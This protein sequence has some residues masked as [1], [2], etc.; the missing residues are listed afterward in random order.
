[1]KRSWLSLLGGMLVCLPEGQAQGGP[2]DAPPGYGGE[3]TLKAASEARDAKNQQTHREDSSKLVLPGLVADRVAKRIEVLA[4]TTELEK[5]AIIEFLLID[6]SCGRGYESLLWSFAKPSDV[7]HALEFIGLKSGEPY[8]PEAMRFWPKGERVNMTLQHSKD[9]KPARME[10]LILDKRTGKTLEETGFMFTGSY[11]IPQE[12]P[13]HGGAYASDIFEPKSIASIFNM[14]LTVLDIPTRSPER[15]VYGK[16]VLHPE[17]WFEPHTLVTL[18]IEPQRRDG[19]TRAVDLKLTLQN[20]AREPVVLSKVYTGEDI[21]KGELT[22]ALAAFE[23]LAGAGRDLFVQLNFAADLPL[24]QARTHAH[25]IRAIDN[26]AGIR[27]EPP[28]KGQLFYEAFSPR[29]EI[30]DREKRFVHP[31]ELDLKPNND[32]ELEGT[33][34]LYNEEYDEADGQQLSASQWPV[35]SSQ[36]LA[37]QIRLENARRE[38]A[39]DFPVPAALLVYAD[40]AMAYGDVTQFIAQAFPEG[41]GTVYVFL[42]PIEHSTTAKGN[43]SEE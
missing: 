35:K 22:Q 42:Q 27:V 32:G 15:D 34:W 10:S 9:T 26:D 39:E 31:W 11:R 3:P 14:R 4:E 7:H 12:A 43:V 28:L 41:D 20:N 8:H 21:A 23:K 6:Q 18:V 24:Q 37:D 13:A 1:M 40:P 2:G 5:G 30:I 33:L 25:L 29:A 16:L 36:A 17:A 19:T 38:A